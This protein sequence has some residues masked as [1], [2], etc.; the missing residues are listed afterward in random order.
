MKIEEQMREFDTEP[1]ALAHRGKKILVVAL[2]AATLAAC[3]VDPMPLGIEE[4]HAQVEI[5]KLGIFVEQ[6]AISGPITLEEALARS[7][8]YNLDHRMML[9]EEVQRDSQ[10]HLSKYDMLPSLAVNAGYTTRSNDNLNLNRDINTGVLSNNPS[11]S[12]DRNLAYANLG[13]T[14]NI[15]D[16]GVGYFQAH[17]NADQF[18]IAQERKRRVV[19]Q[20]VQQVRA[21][22]WRA[23]TAEPLYEQIQPLLVEAR[24]ALV[25]A[26]EVETQRLSPALEVLQ[27]QKGLVEVVRELEALELDLA[28]AKTELSALMGLAPGTDFS[29]ALPAEDEMTVPELKLS[30]EEM[31]DMALMNRPELI[32]EHYQQ[33][34]SSI[35]AKKALLRLFPGV[36]LTTSINEDSNSYLV[37]QNWAEAGARLTWN[38]LNLASGPAAMRAARASEDVAEVRRLALSMAALTQVHVS[39]QQYRRARVDYEQALLLDDIE[40]RIYGYVR[41]SANNQAQSPLQQIRARMAAIYAEVSSYRAYAEVHSAIAN[42]YVSVGLDLLPQ[43]V[44]SHDIDVLAEGIRMVLEDWNRGDLEGYRMGT[45]ASM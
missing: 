44:E 40:Q 4:Q 39:Y 16:F 28:I 9:M 15:L 18:L 26:R 10:L 31:E 5:D 41:E 23:A 25:D 14:W 20:I 42:L 22:Y 43:T 12:Q 35:E 30:L 37:N 21:S 1:N 38:L 27:Y 13:L 2:A 6:E 33:R 32:E 36:T 7:L 8:K 11:L 17:Q 45:E 34:I 29:L 3:A 19:N 24:Q